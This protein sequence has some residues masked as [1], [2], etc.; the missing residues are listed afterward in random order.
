MAMLPQMS[1]QQ[2]ALILNGNQRNLLLATGIRQRKNIG[3]TI[4][5]LGQT[6][7]V[8][9][10]N[11]GIMT[12]I[13]IVISVP[14][15]IGVATAVASPRA[16]YNLISRIKLTDYDG[17]DRL[18]MSGYQLFV[19][20]CVRSRMPYGINNDG[21]V[22][23]AGGSAQLGGIVTNP[24]TPTA[25][26]NGTLQFILD[27]PVAYDPETDLRGAILAQ[28]AVGQMWL[29]IDWASSL[30]TANNIDAVYTGAGTTT[31]AL[32][33][34]TTG[35]TVQVFQHYLM[36]QNVG[37]QVPLPFIDLQTVYELNGS[38]RDNANIAAGAEKLFSLPNVRSI[39][40]AYINFFNNSTMQANDISTFRFIV[41]GNNI[42]SEHTLF[43]QQMF[44]RNY[45]SGDIANGT[46][47]FPYRSK[48]V[49]TQMIGNA[50][51]G[52]TPSSVA[53]A[54]SFEYC[55]E[56]FYTKNSALPGV[57]IN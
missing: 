8:L 50:Q 17:T 39:I 43:T 35:P 1:D 22:L 48:P 19:L 11:I 37:G 20:N 33:A 3:S 4:G 27:V 34:G 40:G 31:V 25:V 47:F 42:L 7:R 53:G 6:T 52:V 10:S 13:Q 16:P 57:N 32:A 18:N 12:G 26:G 24:S 36:P 54:P 14:L 49:E 51:I 41:N 56:G 45:I 23:N 28:T 9:L 15:T 5:A 30:L 46:Y 38:L 29:S 55:W 2:K 44:Q 21:P